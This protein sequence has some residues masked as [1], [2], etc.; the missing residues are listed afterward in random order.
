MLGAKKAPP[1]VALSS[2]HSTTYGSGLEADQILALDVTYIRP[3]RRDLRTHGAEGAGGEEV[4]VE[5]DDLVAGA[6]QH[7]D[8]HRT[9]VAVVTGDEYAQI[10]P[11]G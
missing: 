8:E 2:V 6:L 7:G 9:D 4:G 11:P 3:Q 1:T 5:S 10:K